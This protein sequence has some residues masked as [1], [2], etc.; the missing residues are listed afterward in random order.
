MGIGLYKDSL[1][2]SRAE[3]WNPGTRNLAPVEV[4]APVAPTGEVWLIV[5]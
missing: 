1:V 4:T 5:T 3:V 2:S